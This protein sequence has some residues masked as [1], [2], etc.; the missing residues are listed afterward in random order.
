M[1]NQILFISVQ[2]LKG[3]IFKN[4]WSYILQVK[5]RKHH[6]SLGH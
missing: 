5:T 1:L 3:N 4:K 2:N 6:D